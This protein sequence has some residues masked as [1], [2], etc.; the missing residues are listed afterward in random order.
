MATVFPSA[1]DAA[2]SSS[3]AAAP[4]IGT[5]SGD[6]VEGDVRWGDAARPGPLSEQSIGR[7]WRWKEVQR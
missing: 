7:E 3:A 5:S 6:V 1:A 2:L 4:R